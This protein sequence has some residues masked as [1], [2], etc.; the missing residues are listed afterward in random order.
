[1]FTNHKTKGFTLVETLVALSILSIALAGTY[2][3]ISYNL[4]SAKGIQNSFIASGLA[5][6]GL[7]VVRNLR[8]TDWFAENPFG[9]LGSPDDPP[10]TGFTYWVQWDS[11]SLLSADPGPLLLNSAGMYQYDGGTPTI[12][13]RTVNVKRIDPGTGPVPELIV[14][15]NVA[16]SEGS[17]TKNLQGEEHLFNWY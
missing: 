3:M 17:G 14:T 7:E 6:E 16:W 12:F 9:S 15:V 13:S 11:L 10:R 8:D 1:M 5:Q 2:T 4:R